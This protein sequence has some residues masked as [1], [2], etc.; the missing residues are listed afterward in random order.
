VRRF[1]PPIEAALNLFGADANKVE[2]IPAL[3]RHLQRP[4]FSRHGWK[5][6]NVK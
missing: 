4:F 6:R 1:R 5:M 2:R 3:V